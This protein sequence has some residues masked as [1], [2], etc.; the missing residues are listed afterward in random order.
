MAKQ[1]F[2][3]KQFQNVPAI[4]I[5]GISSIRSIPKPPML[6]EDLIPRGAIVMVSGPSHTGKTFFAAELAR[7]L[8]LKQPWGGNYEIPQAEN[9]LFIEQDAPKLDTGRVIW[10]MVRN[11]WIDPEVWASQSPTGL[12][13]QPLEALNFLWHKGLNLY[14]GQD[15]AKVAHT[16]RSCSFHGGFMSYF[17][18]P[19]FDH[20]GDLI[21]AGGEQTEEAIRRGVGLIVYDSFRSLHT[22]EE[23]D[24]GEMEAVMQEL[25]WIREETG[26][27]QVIL[28]HEN[29]SGERP[30]GS[31]AIEAAM[32]T[33][34]RLKRSPNSNVV[35]CTVAK[36]RIVQPES[37]KYQI[38]S[39][40]DEH[41]QAV[42]SVRFLENIEPKESNEIPENVVDSASLFKYIQ[43]NSGLGRHELLGWGA[44][45]GKSEA[46]LTR[47]ISKLV[48]AGSLRVERDNQGARYWV[49]GN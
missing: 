31:T 22:A 45:N 38:L 9:T 37:F 1:R 12:E 3:G 4:P 19:R 48:K 44:L 39:T 2:S 40:E 35:I 23:N 14:N 49:K 34:F 30:R 21:D 46:T 11:A 47:W 24:S 43:S 16:G 26:A 6:V 36:A 10:A 27:T 42:K 18:P 25:K 29:S 13:D 33:I 15:A 7:A 41:G 8:A 5:E 28:H 17:N 32:D 20:N